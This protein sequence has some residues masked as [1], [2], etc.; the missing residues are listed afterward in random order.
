MTHPQTNTHARLHS[1]DVPS[2]VSGDYLVLFDPHARH[3]PGISPAQPGLKISFQRAALLQ[4]FPDAA[5]PY[6]HFGCTLRESYPGEC[7]AVAG[8]GCGHE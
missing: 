8:P 4:Q 6:L 3:L 1:T 5:T 2:F 7:M